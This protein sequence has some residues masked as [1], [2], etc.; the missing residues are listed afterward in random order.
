M[1]RLPA[2]FTSA[3][4]TVAMVAAHGAPA[5]AE[6]RH[7]VRAGETLSEIAAR[8]GTTTSA[9][10]RANGLSNA[11]RI[12]AGQVLVIP[13]GTDAAA[14]ATVVH[15][16]APGETLSGIAAHYGTTS[17]TLADA[18]GITNRNLVRIGQRLTVPTGGQGGAAAP[19][20]PAAVRHTVAPGETLAVI[21]RRLGSS[22]GAIVAANG[23]ANPNLV[24]AGQVLSIPST[25]APVAGAGPSTTSYASTGS[26]DGRT[27]VA[28]THTVASGETL[29]GIAARYGIAPEALAAANGIPQPWDL[30]AQ[31]RL[32]LSAPNRFPVDIGQCP[33]P[34]STFAN[35][36]GFPRSGGRAHAGNDMFAPRGTAVLAPV[37]GSVS[38]STGTIGGKQ[39][40]LTGD[41]GML[42]LG[43][44][45]DGFGT[46]G[47]VGAGTVIGYVGTTGNAAGGRP[48]L[49][50]EIHPDSGPAMNPY[51]VISAA[52]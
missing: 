19:S 42:Y 1:S 32:S 22:V 23:I 29:R 9:M 25:G 4:L 34:G 27:G 28:G 5:A 7:T 16:V 50:F 37:A 8:L 31:A 47:R 36:W 24:L 6:G 13:S 40:R 15:V 44:H 26:S 39:F 3:L 11:D 48:H 49:H 41:D 17:R 10:A 52:C 21:A 38:F 45:M 35:D 14:P 33:V 30:Y 20:T 46:S 18:N 12:L 51:P 43:S 2:L